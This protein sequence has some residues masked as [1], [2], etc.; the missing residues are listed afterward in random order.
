MPGWYGGGGEVE[1]LWIRIR[2]DPKLLAGHGSGKNHSGS[3][4]LRIQNE[5]EVNYSEKLIKFLNKNAQLKT[6][7]SF[8]SK[9]IPTKLI[10][11]HNMQSNTLKRR[12]Y[13]S[14]IYMR[15]II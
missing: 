5:F 9:K 7:N 2:M 8:L 6:I 11:N 12:K 13:K 4:Q 10:S 3:G 15:I 1:V 14:K